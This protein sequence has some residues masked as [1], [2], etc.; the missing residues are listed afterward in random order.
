MRRDI[1]ELALGI[2]SHQHHLTALRAHHVDHSGTATLA[3][4]RGSPTHLAQAL[5]MLDDITG[6]RISRNPIDELLALLVAPDIRSSGD[7]F[8]GFYDG[9]HGHYCTSNNYDS[10]PELNRG[11]WRDLR[12]QPALPLLDAQYFPGVEVS[13]LTDDAIEAKHARR[14][15][16]VAVTLE[17]LIVITVDLHLTLGDVLVR[18]GIHKLNARTGR[19]LSGNEHL[20]QSVGVILSTPIGSRV[21][22]RDFG[23]M[24]PALLSQPLNDA[25]VLRVYAAA[26][27]ALIRWEPRISISRIRRVVSTDAPGKMALEIIGTSRV[28]DP[29][30]MEVVL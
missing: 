28:G 8:R 4:A 9:E 19:C 12:A 20:A 7:K 22:R 24:L 25:T 13:H 5:R 21:M 27:T 26:V 23:S 18:I 1:V 11:N 10:N 15:S 14:A 6:F 16:Q 17:A 3:A 2:G 30:T 29:I